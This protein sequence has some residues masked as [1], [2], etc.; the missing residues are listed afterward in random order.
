[1][2]DLPQ[3]PGIRQR[4]LSDIN[5]KEKGGRVYTKDKRNWYSAQRLNDW[6]HSAR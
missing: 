2:D 1:M 3:M 6:K 5:R 4:T